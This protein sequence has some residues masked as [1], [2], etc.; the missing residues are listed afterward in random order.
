L[1]SLKISDEDAMSRAS[2]KRQFPQYNQVELMSSVS[3]EIL[4]KSYGLKN[5]FNSKEH[6]RIQIGIHSGPVVAGIVGFT[7]IQFCLFG[8]TVNT[9]SRMCSNS[10]VD[11]SWILFNFKNVTFLTKCE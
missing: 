6:L 8:D 2:M 5:P 9:S 7:N 11:M 3:L 10:E 4:E 1:A